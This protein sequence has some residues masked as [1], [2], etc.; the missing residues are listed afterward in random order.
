MRDMTDRIDLRTKDRRREVRLPVDMDA[1][2]LPGGAAC[3][4]V[5]S[6][7]GGARVRMRQAVI[8]PST[9]VLIEWNSGRAHEGQVVW[10]QG[11]EA[12]LKLIRSCDL[13][14][15]VPAAFVAAKSA[16]AGGG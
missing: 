4:I 5:D 13:R 8:L 16:W 7:P 10:R 11:A 1:R 2:I 3:R 14:G 6:S 9:C 15:I 12:G